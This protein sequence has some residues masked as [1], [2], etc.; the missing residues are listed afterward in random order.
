MADEEVPP[1][2]ERLAEKMHAEYLDSEVAIATAL[3]EAGGALDVE[4][5]V[6]ATG[7]TE[8]TVKK[9]IDSLE[10]RL[11]GEPLL[12]RPDQE[13]VRLH[14]RVAAALRDHEG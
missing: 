9:R 14:S 11:G 2:L 6:D 7:Y 5:L 8:R 12:Y 10:E 4:A 3:A 13:Q 1:E